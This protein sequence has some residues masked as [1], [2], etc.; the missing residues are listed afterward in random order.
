M[1]NLQTRRVATGSYHI[2]LLVW[3]VL[4]GVTIL[5]MIELGYLFG[6]SESVNWLFIITL[7]LPLSGVMILIVDLDRSGSGTLGAIRVSQQ[8]L[9]DLH[10]RLYGR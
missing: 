1:V 6:R 4:F 8:P 3:G 2:P 5:S 9:L 10:E 7:S